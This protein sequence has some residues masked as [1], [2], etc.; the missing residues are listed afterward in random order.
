MRHETS[1]YEKEFIASWLP[2]K[3]S[4]IK[5]MGSTHESDAG[6]DRFD[7]RA[8]I[9]PGFRLKSIKNF[10]IRK[11]RYWEGLLPPKRERPEWSES[12]YPGSI[13]NEYF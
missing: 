5:T 4:R 7:W 12:I 11:I 2:R 9:Y 1:V 8:T 6:P 13:Q 3:T 10:V